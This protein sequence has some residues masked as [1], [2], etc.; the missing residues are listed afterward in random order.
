MPLILLM[1]MQ[2]YP[3]PGHTAPVMPR[4]ATPVRSLT[5]QQQ[6]KEYTLII[7]DTIIKSRGGQLHAIAVNGQRPPGIIM[8]PINAPSNLHIYNRTKDAIYLELPGK[9]V[10]KKTRITR[11]TLP[12]GADVN[13]RIM[14]KNAEVYTYRI[15]QLEQVDNGAL[16]S[17][18]I[19]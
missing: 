11:Q 4:T 7:T 2:S 8:I 9:L 12:K 3:A 17:L 1:N 16:G 18:V 15:Y 13:V 14:T 5:D 19:Q 6:P 10:T